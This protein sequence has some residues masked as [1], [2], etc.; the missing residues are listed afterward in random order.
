M[1]CPCQRA[2]F[3]ELKT[4]KELQTSERHSTTTELESR[5]IVVVAQYGRRRWASLSSRRHHPSRRNP[6]SECRAAEQEQQAPPTFMRFG[7]C[8]TQ[9][10]E[11]LRSDGN[12]PKGDWPQVRML[13]Y[14]TPSTSKFDTRIVLITARPVYTPRLVSVSVS[15]PAPPTASGRKLGHRPPVRFGPPV[16]F[17]VLVYSQSPTVAA[18]VS[19]NAWRAR[20]WW[21]SSVECER[22]PFVR[23]LLKKLTGWMCLKLGFRIYHR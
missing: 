22:L 17:V 4:L 9:E 18:V 8:V 6:K 16:V 23:D 2:F 1:R 21:W 14:T 3:S 13:Q 5:A 20:W 11:Q 10:H 7:C 19:R 15:V 12:H